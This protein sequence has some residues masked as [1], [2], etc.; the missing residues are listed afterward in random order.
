MFI[1]RTLS[2]TGNGPNAKLWRAIGVGAVVAAALF[3]I[4]SANIT[5]GQENL[6]AGQVAVR[7]IRAPRDA[8]FD[9]VSETEAAREAAAAGVQP[10]IHQT[11]PPADNQA[12]QLALFD[13]LNRRVPVRG[14]FVVRGQF[15]PKSE[16]GR[17]IHGAFDDGLAP[18]AAPT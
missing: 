10:A 16:Q 17:L 15:Q 6:E 18:S 3:L 1:P 13:M 7:D 4:L 5:L 9:S 8:T 11:E 2:E 14:D 12:D